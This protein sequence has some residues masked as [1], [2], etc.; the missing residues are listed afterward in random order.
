[1]PDKNLP[2]KQTVQEDEIDLVELLCVIVKRWKILAST[3]CLGIG[4]GLFLVF[5]YLPVLYSSTVTMLPPT[6]GQSDAASLASRLGEVGQMFGLGKTG[7]Q[8]L[9]SLDLCKAMLKSR[10]L[11]REMARRFELPEH[12]EME[13]QQAEY[14]EKQYISAGN[15]LKE[16]TRIDETEEGLITISVDDSAAEYATRLANGYVDVLKELKDQFVKTDE[17]RRREFLE[18]RVQRSREEL[19]Q[20][21]EKL[22]RFQEKHKTVAISQQAEAV[23]EALKE[24][25]KNYT[26]L[27]VELGVEKK[28]ATSEAPQVQRLEENL[29]ELDE[30]IHK[31]EFGGDT[32]KENTQNRDSEANAA[33][34]DS[35]RLFMPLMNIPRIGIEYAHLYG[36]VQIQQRIFELLRKEFELAKIEERKH[37]TVIQIMDSAI[38]PENPSKPRKKL[39]LV[40][41][42]FAAGFLGL[43]LCFLVEFVCRVLHDPQR[44]NQIHTYLSGS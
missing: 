18:Q 30:Q 15:Q 44:R 39:V 13:K 24:L 38:Q 14:T 40:V 11:L 32:N 2:A 27:E 5:A 19:A 3:I 26:E 1:M 34:A 20:A 41:A 35:S 23:M 36:E 16:M 42:V 6:G 28:F 9:S 31:L 22:R 17:T 7:G 4:A 33:Q 21:Q 37:P 8:G 43:F 25:K 12:Y 10:R 29:K